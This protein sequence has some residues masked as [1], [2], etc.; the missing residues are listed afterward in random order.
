MNVGLLLRFAGTGWLLLVAA[1]AQ[2]KLAALSLMSQGLCNWPEPH[3]QTCGVGECAGATAGAL[4]RCRDWL[5]RLGAVAVD[6]QQ[7]QQLGA[8]TGCGDSA[9]W[10]EQ[11]P[12]QSWIGMLSIWPAHSLRH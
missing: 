10:P 11:S 8:T 6:D 4:R 7:S 3:A 12:K 2:T 5:Q 1:V 9:S